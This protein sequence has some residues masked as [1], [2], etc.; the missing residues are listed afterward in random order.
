MICTYTVIVL[1]SGCPPSRSSPAIGGRAVDLDHL[2]LLVI[3]GAWTWLALRVAVSYERMRRMMAARGSDQA[4]ALAMGIMLAS[5][6]AGFE[7]LWWLLFQ[8]GHQVGLDLWWMQAGKPWL[9]PFALLGAAGYLI[10]LRSYHR[11]QG[12]RGRWRAEALAAV[13]FGLA[14]AGTVYALG[15][16]AS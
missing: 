15:T 9:V 4:V 7:Q 16:V 12:R 8:T 3:Y 1:G 14:L 13:L 2:G 11:E 10:H 5:A 6:G